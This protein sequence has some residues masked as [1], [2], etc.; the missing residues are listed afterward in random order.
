MNN[1]RWTRRRASFP[2]RQN[3]DSLDHVT[4]FHCVSLVFVNWTLAV[5]CE[6]VIKSL[7]CGTYLFMPRSSPRNALFE[8]G[9]EGLELKFCSNSCLG[10][11]AG[12]KM[13]QLPIWLHLVGERGAIYDRSSWVRLALHFNVLCGITRVKLS[14]KSSS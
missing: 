7:L 9:S 5:P 11:V 6:A 13:I 10:C 1:F 2:N 12:C 14:I 8:I 3:L 4:V